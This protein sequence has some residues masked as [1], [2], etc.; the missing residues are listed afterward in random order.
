MFNLRN[1]PK[2]CAILWVMCLKTNAQDDNVA[3]MKREHS[4]VKPYQGNRRLYIH[5]FR[6]FIA[7]VSNFTLFILYF[8]PPKGTGISLP[9]WDYQGSTM[10]SSNYVRLT[11]DLQSKKGSIWNQVV[12]EYASLTCF[13]LWCC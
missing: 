5:V 2:L 8:A 11:A 10:V 13:P 9:F 6:I 7:I 12:R 1:L 3:Y 4:L